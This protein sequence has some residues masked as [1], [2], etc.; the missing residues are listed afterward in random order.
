M[1]PEE[2]ARVTV[3]LDRLQE[4]FAFVLNASRRSH[5]QIVI[6]FDGQALVVTRAK[7]SAPIP[8]VGSWPGT[9]SLY[10]QGL[11][12]KIRHL[13]APEGMVTAKVSGSQL[14]IGACVFGCEWKCRRKRVSSTYRWKRADVIDMSPC[15]MMQGPANRLRQGSGGSRSRTPHLVSSTRRP[16]LRPDRDASLPRS[17]RVRTRSRE[18]PAAPVRR[19]SPRGRPESAR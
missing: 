11:L 14:W 16:R 19:R 13:S 10:D 7:V 2:A 12:L 18:S 17:R 6:T 1:A 8:A 15:R 3:K 4:G 9:V 5:A